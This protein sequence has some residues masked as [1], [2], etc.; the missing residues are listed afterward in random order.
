MGVVQGKDEI[1]ASGRCVVVLIRCT[2]EV[3]VVIGIEYIRTA[4][5]LMCRRTA[6]VAGC[7]Y[8]HSVA[9]ARM[10]VGENR[11][12]GGCDPSDVR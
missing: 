1:A 10:S 9:I 8:Q 6:E 4:C 2:D 7:L 5:Y 12:A 3:Q 11:V